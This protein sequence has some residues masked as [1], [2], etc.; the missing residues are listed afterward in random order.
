MPTHHRT[1]FTTIRTEGAIL[2]ADLLQRIAEGD[3]SLGGLTPE[4]YHLAPGEKINEAI[5]RAWNRCLGAWASFQSAAAKLAEDDLGTSITRERWLLPL[6]Q[7]L[8]YGRLVPAK[9]IEIEGKSY[10]ISH[11]WQNTPIHLVGLKVDLDKRTPGVTGASRSSPHSLVQEL[12]NRSSEHLWGIVSNGLRLRVLRD[13]ASLTR[14]A[15][16]EFDLQAMMDGEVYADFALLWLV[17][18]Q[19]RVETG[20]GSGESGVGATHDSR[21][22][23]PADCWLEKWMKAAHDQ[24]TRALDQ[25]RAGVEKAIEALGRGFVSQPG[26]RA[27]RAKLQ[28]GELSAQEFYRQLLRLVY[29]LIF[30]F[31]AEERGL[32]LDPKADPMAQERYIRYY[33][34]GRLRRLAE[35]RVGTRHVDLYH[36]VRLVMDALGGESG[37][38]NGE[39]GVANRDS[40]PGSRLPTPNTALGLPILGSF[41]FSREATPDLDGCEIANRDFLDAIRALAFIQSKGTRRLIDYKNLGSQEW[42]SVYTSLLELHPLVNV[43]AANGEA[44]TFELQTAAGNE[45]KTTGSYYT[46]PGLVNELI[47][48]ALEPVIQERL[49]EIGNR[50]SGVGKAAIPDSRLPIAVLKER[51]L[52]SI[53]VCD[54][55]SGSGHMLIA[56]GH[57]LA[58]HLAIIR[59]GDEEPSPEALRTALRDV[60]GHCLYGVDINPMAVELCKVNLWMEALEPGKPLSFLDHHIKCGNSLIGVPVGIWGVGNRDASQGAGNRESGIDDSRFTTSHSRLFIPDEAFTPIEG[61][62][63]K[64]CSEFKKKNKQEREGQLSLFDAALQPWERVGDIA[65]SLLQLDELADDTIDGVRRKQAQY[66]ALVQ[67]SGYE[68]GQLWADSWCAAFVWKKSKEFPYPITEEVFRR[69]ERNPFDLAPWMK[70]EI[71]RLRRQYQFFHWHL[72]FPEIFGGKWGIGSGESD[73]ATPDSLLPTPGFDVLLS[74]PPWERIKLQE[75]EFFA[76]RDPKIASAANKAARQKLIEALPKTNPALARE[77]VEAKREH[78]GFSMFVRQ[79]GRYPLTA[80]GDV[81]TYALF[82]EL[83]RNLISSN[84]RAGI[85]VPTGIATDDTT[86]DFFG[87]LSATRTLAGLLDFENREGL[88]P[89]VDSRFKFSLLTMCR[90]P[91]KQT[92]LVFFAT[93][94]EHLRDERRRF[95][96]ESS[97]IILFNPNTR[98]MPVFRT[99]A[100]AEL[101]HKVYQHV[102]VLINEQTGENPWG[103]RLMSMFHMSNDSDIFSTEPRPGLVRLYES[104]LIHQFDHR[105]ATY[106]GKDVRDLTLSEKRD[107]HYSSVPRYWVPL[108]EVNARLGE[109]THDWQIGL[110]DTARATDERTAIFSIVPRTGASNKTP[111]VFPNV[112]DVRLTACFLANAN[113]LVFDFVVR[114]KVASATLNFF[115]IKQ[116]PF[117]PPSAYTAAD[118]AYIAPRV[119]E[120]VYTAWDLKP[121]AEDMWNGSGESGVENSATA[122]SRFTTPDSRFTTPDSLDTPRHFRKLIIQQWEANHGKSIR[123]ILPGLASVA[124]GDDAGRDV[125]SSDESISE[126]GSLRHDLTDSPS[127]GLGSGQHRRGLRTGEPGGIHS[128]SPDRT[129][130]IEGSGDALDSVG[131]SGLDAGRS[132]GRSADTMRDSGED[133]AGVDSVVTG[134]DRESGVGNS[135]S[136]PDS[137]LS[138]PDLPIP[139]FRWDEERRAHLRAELDAYYARLYGLTR[140]ELRYV[141]DPQEVYGSDFPG[142]TFRVLKEKE[143]KMYGEYRTRRLVLEVWDRLEGLA[144]V[145]PVLP[146]VEVVIE[147]VPM[148]DVPKIRWIPVTPV[149]REAEKKPLSP[150]FR[151]AV[152]VAWLLENFGTGQSILS[153]D[154]QKYC[155]FLQ[156]KG[157][158]ELN[159]PYREFARGPYSPE[160]TYH[161][162]TYAKKQH[163]WEIRGSNIA[164]RQNIKQAI[165]AAPRVFT[166][167]DQARQLV[168]Q[169]RQMSKEDLGG[170]ATVDFAS[171]E[172]YARGQA[173][174]P[175]SIRAYFVSSWTDKVNDPWYTDENINRAMDLLLKLGLFEKA[176]MER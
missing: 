23:T 150:N 69:I 122:D 169:L 93:R 70:E 79:S 37:R 4:A 65:A 112:S 165:I 40:T 45:R 64:V 75:E 129:G 155:Y 20:M 134:E 158:A 38:E 44:G 86:K 78:E 90:E 87:D 132:G 106:D 76:V 83:A 137:L 170:L 109:W 17:G 21:L 81:N 172:V 145:Q 140:D 148:P 96:L 125:L 9:A 99:H 28:A 116:F 149:P 163:F 161:A 35:R 74:N 147:P 133:A 6:F 97:D 159:I 29:R 146:T 84:G 12:L 67:S 47:E 55:A 166:D 8:G 151:Q 94:V 108:T 105:W 107:P 128:I 131:A 53:K 120:L 60:I 27:L 123:S 56:A 102:P 61:D 2:P 49:R 118:I 89:E 39:L 85:I 110:R 14:Q 95:K 138:T 73:K 18:H 50:E 19:S 92:D 115:V 10:A 43:G 22:T 124:G 7:E 144:T 71:L 164:R 91:V 160:V 54:F 143:M 77:F 62:D 111:L 130:I 135:E 100:D 127:G 113:G 101:T 153:F 141:L 175:E 41:L 42:G 80:V 176:K 154:A 103:V 11:G 104:K 59:S 24:G 1:T 157:L 33:S 173:I 26:N 31:T 34:I 162:G 126:R 156:R 57:R 16:V 98:T 142:E 58:R 46:E 52:L 51:A 114:Q 152:G 168:E 121:F 174:T 136:I 36:G 72:E 30:L 171:R 48:S 88:F 117:L 68:Y 5:N 167:I 13:N 63:K 119:L 32:L 139:P 66:A 82:A 15:Y 3:T 25:L